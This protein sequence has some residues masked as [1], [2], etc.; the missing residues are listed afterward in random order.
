MSPRALFE[1]QIS[2]SRI[3]LEA[4]YS[5]SFEIPN[6]TI[7][8]GESLC[9]LDSPNTIVEFGIS[10]EPEY[11]ASSAIRDSEISDQDDF[12]HVSNVHAQSVLLD[13]AP[14][15]FVPRSQTSR[16]SRTG[17]SLHKDSPNTIVEFGISKEPEYVASSAIRDSEISD[18][19]RHTPVPLKFQTRRLY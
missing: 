5:G 19:R 10:K 9:R 4:T 14:L 13:L 12:R 3:A 15:Y 17:Q 7:V 2:E 11:V 6:S 16:L 18:S 1:I 8:L